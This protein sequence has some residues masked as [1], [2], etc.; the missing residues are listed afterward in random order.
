MPTEIELKKAQL[1]M[2]SYNNYIAIRNQ[3]EQMNETLKEAHECLCNAT[4]LFLGI[5][6]D[7]MKRVLFMFDSIAQDAKLVLG[8]SNDSNT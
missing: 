6:D 4:A 1:Y 2:D 8:V 5:S 3:L 7:E